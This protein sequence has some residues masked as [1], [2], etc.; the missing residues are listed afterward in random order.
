MTLC[1]D[2]TIQC[3]RSDQ[4]SQ[5]VNGYMGHEYDE[6]ITPLKTRAMLGEYLIAWRRLSL[7]DSVRSDQRRC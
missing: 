1:T 4:L 5:T 6:S 2:D 3:H 7:A